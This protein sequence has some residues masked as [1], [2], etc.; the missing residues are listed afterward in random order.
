MY[1]TMYSAF[2]ILVLFIRT[3][4]I[5]FFG[6]NNNWQKKADITSS[7]ECLDLNNALLLFHSF[8]KYS[9]VVPTH[10]NNNQK[11]FVFS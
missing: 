11:N 1:V 6:K 4:T 8:S 10:T 7:A 2:T 5:T 3:M 9:Y